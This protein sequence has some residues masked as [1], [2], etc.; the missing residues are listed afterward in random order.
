MDV[1]TDKDTADADG[2]GEE[3]YRR[4][5]WG[6]GDGTHRG[7]LATLAGMSKEPEHKMEE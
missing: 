5:G 4:G 6:A 3:I 2:K 1:R 7:A